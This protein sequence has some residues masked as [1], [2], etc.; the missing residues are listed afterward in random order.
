M[1]QAETS[2]VLEEFKKA[3]AEGRQPLCSYC[4]EPLEIGQFY[5]V[6]VHWSWNNKKKRFQKE[7]PYWDPGSPF[8][9]A[10][11]T[12]DWDFINTGPIDFE[13]DKDKIEQQTGTI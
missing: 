3:K 12:K 8:C 6:Y 5:S 2:D 9:D 13:E 11:E 7:E 4:H 1:E 10:C